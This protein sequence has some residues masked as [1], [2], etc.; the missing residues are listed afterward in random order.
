MHGKTYVNF[1]AGL[2]VLAGAVGTVIYAADPWPQ[3]RGPKADGYSP[4]KGINKDWNAKPPKQLWKMDLGDNGYSGPIIADGK[5]FIIDYKAG[6]DIVRCLDAQTGKEA[7]NYPYDNGGKDNYGF[8]RSTP[9]YDNG[10]LYTVG[11]MGH[12]VCLDA[13]TG[14]KVWDLDMVKEYGGQRPG[15]EYGM[16]PLVDGDLVI[17]V[18]GAK[19]AAAVAVNKATGKLAWKADFGDKPGYS[20]PL[21][22]TIGGKKQYIIFSAANLMGLDPASGKAIWKFAWPTGC[23]CNAAAPIVEGNAIFIT[24]GY[25]HGCG[26]VEVAGEQA[27]SLWENKDIQSHFSSPIYA[28][29]HVYCTSNTGNLTCMELKTGSVKWKK[30]GFEKGGLIAADGAL[31]VM[32]GSTGDVVMIEINSKEY[33]ELGRIKK[34]ASGSKQFWTA[35]VLADGKLLV[36]SNSELVCLDAK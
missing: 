30:R 3:F 8:S 14:K 15:W 18:P 24:S 11:K 6:K 32:D 9:A 28:D 34:P 13:K 19:D 29:G 23:D 20:T 33:K 4:D 1:V 7:W 22:A 5:V 2:I 25:N 35:P 12:V 21:A 31:I 16:S 17:L 10:K 27:K 26:L 36:R